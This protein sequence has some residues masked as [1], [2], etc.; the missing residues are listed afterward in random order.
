MAYVK[1][2][3]EPGEQVVYAAS[4]TQLFYYYWVILGLAPV[5]VSVLF[6]AGA[7]L[8]GRDVDALYIIVIFVIELLAI[9][10]ASAILVLGYD[11][12]LTNRRLLG[13]PGFGAA[14]L[15]LPWG[16]VKEVSFHAGWLERHLGVPVATV[17][18]TAASGKQIRFLAPNLE[19]LLAEADKAIAGRGGG[20][21]GG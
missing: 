9:S 17:S 4:R 13:R 14:A 15:G 5:T 21:S 2:R 1:D 7:T 19:R 6:A 8:V 3:L 10:L 12:A 18:V 11:L 16:E 20:T